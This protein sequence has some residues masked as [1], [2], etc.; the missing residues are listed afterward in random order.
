[1]SGPAAFKNLPT[2]V[3]PYPRKEGNALAGAGHPFRDADSRCFL[4]SR[5]AER[6]AEAELRN[7]DSR[8]RLLKLSGD[9]DARRPSRP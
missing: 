4:L 6:L 5:A 2:S 7:A 1:M 3:R 9:S 8:H